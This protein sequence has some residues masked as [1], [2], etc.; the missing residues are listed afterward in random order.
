[1]K[2]EERIQN[3]IAELNAKLLFIHSDV[4]QGF[5]I[6]FISREALLRDHVSA[7]LNLGKGINIW[8]PAFN[9]SF[10]SGMD[11]SIRDTPSQVGS[12]SEY[13]RREI[14]N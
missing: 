7:L 8:M 4:S 9:Y 13:F 3:K 11:F 10:C 14:A 5:K 2:V 12:I 1:M 6:P